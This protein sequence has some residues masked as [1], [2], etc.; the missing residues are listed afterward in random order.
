MFGHVFVNLHVGLC[1]AMVYPYSWLVS[2]MIIW[3]WAGG[4]TTMAMPLPK[5]RHVVQKAPGC[6]VHVTGGCVKS[7]PLSKAWMGE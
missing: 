2:L 3:G 6:D 5:V 7:L 1:K 4:V